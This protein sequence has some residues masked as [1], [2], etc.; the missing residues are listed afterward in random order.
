MNEVSAALRSRVGGQHHAEMDI[1]VDPE[2]GARQ[3]DTQSRGDTERTTKFNG[4]RR[5]RNE[6]GLRSIRDRGAAEA[7]GRS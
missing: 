5:P 4:S 7:G 2:G 3:R 1:M 6:V